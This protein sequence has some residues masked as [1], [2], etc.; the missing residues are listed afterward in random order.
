MLFIE[1]CPEN[2]I[3]TP[4]LYDWRRVT[5]FNPAVIYDNGRFYMLERAAGT[6]RPHKCCLGLL[7]SEDG[8]HFRH[9]VGKPVFTGDD[10]GWPHASIQ[11][12]RLVKID[13][14]YYLTYAAR[15]FPGSAARFNKI[16]PKTYYSDFDATAHDPWNKTFSGLARSTDLIHWENLG[17]VNDVEIDDRDLILFPEKIG[18]RYLLLRRPQAGPYGWTDGKMYFSWSDDLKTWSEMELFA[19]PRQEV[20]N[21]WEG[22]KI[23]GSTPPIRTS[24]GW[25]LLY[26][27]VDE[28]T[29]YRLGAMLLDRED[30]TKIIARTPCPIMEPQED[31][32]KIGLF[33]P[34]VIFPCGNVVVDGKLF[35]YYGCTDMTVGLATVGLEELVDYVLVSDG[36]V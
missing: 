23:G 35:I 20:R 1:R 25:L 6:L 9:V 14:V 26:H 4:G 36:I 17:F 19:A 34:N 8:I 11:D 31:Y 16:D 30:P 15:Q 5:V 24:R 21:G 7:E 12:P 27:G 28:H 13:G 22:K 32:E 10:I 18:G 2:P 29:V 33:I 3:V